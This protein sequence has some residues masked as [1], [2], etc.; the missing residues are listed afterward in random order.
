MKLKLT[1]V[2]PTWLTFDGSL[3]VNKDGTMTITKEFYDA[4]VEYCGDH[5]LSIQSIGGNNDTGEVFVYLNEELE[6]EKAES[7]LM[8]VMLFVDHNGQIVNEIQSEE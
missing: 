3:N 8:K 7:L 1:D 2:H 4:V 6:L 5:G